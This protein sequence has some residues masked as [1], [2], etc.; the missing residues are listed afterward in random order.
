MS[1]FYDDRDNSYNFLTIFVFSGICR[2]TTVLVTIVRMTWEWVKID[3]SANF[4][5]YEN[6][7]GIFNFTDTDYILVI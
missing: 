6:F 3:D 5:F 2:V 4:V 1:R 7:K